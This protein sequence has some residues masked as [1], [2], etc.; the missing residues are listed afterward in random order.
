M[1]EVV[2]AFV[3]GTRDNLPVDKLKYLTTMILETFNLPTVSCVMAAEIVISMNT[4]TS[5]QAHFH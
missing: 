5:V 4:T 2:Y 3:N 1:G